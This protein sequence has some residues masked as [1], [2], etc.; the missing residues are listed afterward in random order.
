MFAAEEDPYHVTMFDV[1]MPKA[2]LTFGCHEQ[3]P[4]DADFDVVIRGIPDGKQGRRNPDAVIVSCEC[5]E[6]RPPLDRPLIRV[7]MP[8]STCEDKLNVLLELRKWNVRIQGFQFIE[9]G[10]QD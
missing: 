10:A 7:A 5:C 3:T 9:Y 6:K 8:P 2:Q 4:I 1:P